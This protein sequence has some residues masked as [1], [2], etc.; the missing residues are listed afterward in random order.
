MPLTGYSCKKIANWHKLECASGCTLSHVAAVA[1][2][3]KGAK[4]DPGSRQG[5]FFWWACLGCGELNQVIGA[6]TAL[7][8]AS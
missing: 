4:N 7:P 8:H 2:D 5:A 6:P 3:V 1:G